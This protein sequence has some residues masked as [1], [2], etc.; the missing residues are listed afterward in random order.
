MDTARAMLEEAGLIKGTQVKRVERPS[1]N[2][3]VNRAVH[4]TTH[5]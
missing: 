2:Y 4:G 3:I 1:R 5:E